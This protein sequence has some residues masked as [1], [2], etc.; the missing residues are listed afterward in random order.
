V[1]VRERVRGQLADLAGGEVFIRE[2]GQGA[3][4]LFV[5]G[6]GGNSTNWTDLMWMLS[7]RLHCVAPDLPGFGR[8]GPAVSGD[9]APQAQAEVLAA[10]IRGRFAEPVHLFGNSMGGAISVQLA[11]RFPDLVRSLTLISPALPDLVPMRT[12]VQ[13]PLI[14]IPGVGQRV[15]SRIA[16]LP[17][18]MRVRTTLNLVY[19]DPASVPPQRVA[20]AEEEV[21]LLAQKPWAGQAFQSA[22]R[23]ILATYLDRG[24]DA[25]WRLA[26]R[27]SVPVLLVYGQQDKLVNQRAARRA[28]RHFLHH[29]VMVLPHSGHVSQMEHPEMVERAWRHLIEPF[30]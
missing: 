8:S 4:A 11:G 25:P 29:R 14:A 12:S 13:L 22:L 17:P 26:E 15:A 10:L 23:G 18:E 9:Y 2:V 5:H 28:S 24:P 1:V 30:A 7:D 27:I 19:A 21:R 3:P 20:E 16:R 6:L